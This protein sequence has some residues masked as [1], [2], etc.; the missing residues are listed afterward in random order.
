VEADGFLD[1]GVEEGEGFD[2]PEGWKGAAVRDGC[3]KFP[4]EGFEDGRVG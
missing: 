3:E 2:L 1:D 4:A